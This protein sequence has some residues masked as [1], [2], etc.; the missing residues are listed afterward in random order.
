MLT[1]KNYIEIV[2]TKIRDTTVFI[3]SIE[4]MDTQ[5][6]IVVA[7]NHNIGFEMSLERNPIGRGETALYELWFWDK[8][9]NVQ[10]SLLAKDK[11]NTKR[12]MILRITE[13][14]IK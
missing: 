9:G 12:K 1:I 6:R 4:E 5:Y 11:I 2:Y 10:R 8:N 13:L 7:N 14:I 3:H